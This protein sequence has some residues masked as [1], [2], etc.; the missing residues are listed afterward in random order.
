MKGKGGRIQRGRC[1]EIDRSLVY[2]LY[3]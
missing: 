2:S 1:D 3:T